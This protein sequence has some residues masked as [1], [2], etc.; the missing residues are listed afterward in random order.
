MNTIDCCLTLVAP[1]A[2]EEALVDHLL[3][4]PEWV[5][6]YTITP[7]EGRGRAMHL[8]GEAEHVSGRSRRVVIETV[9]ARADANALLLHLREAL[10]HPEV[11]WWLSPV[12]EFGR[13]A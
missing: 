6:G 4:H 8:H 7:A 11:A 5:S 12:L 13:F 2:L 3:E 10:H 1:I 9:L